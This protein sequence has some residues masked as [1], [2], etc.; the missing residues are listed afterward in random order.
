MAIPAA[1]APDELVPDLV[2]IAQILPTVALDRRLKIG[3]AQVAMGE[4]PLAVLIDAMAPS[5]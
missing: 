4:Q 3:F 1:T 5:G 2:P